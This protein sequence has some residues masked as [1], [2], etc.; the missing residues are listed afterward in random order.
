MNSGALAFA[1][2]FGDTPNALPPVSVQ[3]RRGVVQ[4]NVVVEKKTTGQRQLGL[5]TQGGYVIVAEECSSANA[6]VIVA[7]GKVVLALPTSTA[8]VF[9]PDLFS[10]P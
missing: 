5:S 8:V 10:L 1:V 9:L 4:K 2:M 3:R 6:R 7:S